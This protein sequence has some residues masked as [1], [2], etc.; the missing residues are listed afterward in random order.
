[1]LGLLGSSRRTAKGLGYFSAK[2]FYPQP[3]I[4]HG[5]FALHL[6]RLSRVATQR[7]WAINCSPKDWAVPV[8]AGAFICQFS[9]FSMAMSGFGKY[10]I[11]DILKG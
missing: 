2:V 3:A 9:G 6:Y 8:M 7:D 10:P 5:I 11:L 1:M 4:W